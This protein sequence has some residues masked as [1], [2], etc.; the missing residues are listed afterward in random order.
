M[1]TAKETV[2]KQGNKIAV[3]NYN[4]EIKTKD[5]RDYIVLPVVMMVEGVHNGSHGPVF[6]SAD[7]LGKSVSAWD[8][9]PITI[10]HPVDS[11]GDFVSVNS[12]EHNFEP[13]GVVKNAH[14]EGTKLKAEAWIDKQ[15]L[16]AVS[17][18]ATQYIQEKR[19]LEVSIGVFNEELQTPG[20]WNNEQYTA[21][22]MNHRP[23]HLALLPSGVGACSW[24]DGCGIR[25]NK[26]GGNMENKQLKALNQQGYAVTLISLA[27]HQQGFQELMSKAYNT[28]NAMDSEQKSHYLEEM[29]DNTM[30]YR[31]RSAEDREGSLYRQSYEIDEAG[32]LNL[33][34][35]AVEVRR[36]VNYMTFEEQEKSKLNVNKNVKKMSEEKKKPCGNCM[37]KVVELINNSDTHFTGADREWLLEL[38]E[39]TLNK[40]FPKKVEVQVNQEQAVQAL[41]D[42]LADTDKLMEILPEKVKNDVQTGLEFHKARKADLVKQIQANTAEGTWEEDDLN[43][44]DIPIL[45]KIAKSANVEGKADYSGQGGSGT[46][47]PA[48][49]GQEEDGPEALYPAG[50]E[51]E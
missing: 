12:N 5:E 18:E 16:I 30:V 34:G 20:E 10:N 6:H 17:V 19:P 43:G 45:E 41:K 3:N 8:N 11:E 42:V 21:I 24:A 13:I 38:D 47:K 48:V 44:M 49:H 1:K 25:V 29:Y 28:L 26:E 39:L 46:Q 23:D 50:I 32:K 2:L 51:I 33:T 14:M 9:I 27:N 36:E 40:L 4:A 31:I 35:Q 7:E 37:E 15:K 22:A